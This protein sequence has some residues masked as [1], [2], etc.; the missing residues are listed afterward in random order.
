[1]EIG[2]YGLIIPPVVAKHKFQLEKKVK[3]EFA[4]ALPR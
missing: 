2:V 3:Q 4:T 1:M